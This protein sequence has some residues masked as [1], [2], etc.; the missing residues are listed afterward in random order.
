[1]NHARI[2]SFCP[3][4]LYIFYFNFFVNSMLNTV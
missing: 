4:S 3:L 1:L 2:I